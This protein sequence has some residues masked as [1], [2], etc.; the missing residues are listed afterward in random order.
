MTDAEIAARLEKLDVIETLFEG[1]R[2]G[3]IQRRWGHITRSVVESLGKPVL[4]V[5]N[6]EISHGPR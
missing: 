5:D 3:A 1:I 4:I 6:P 2:S